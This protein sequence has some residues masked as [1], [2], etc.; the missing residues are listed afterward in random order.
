MVSRR[1]EGLEGQSGG[2]AIVWGPVGPS[3]WVGFKYSPL[4]GRFVV[5]FASKRARI[6]PIA[7]H[8]LEL[9]IDTIVVES[10]GVSITDNRRQ[11][12]NAF[13]RD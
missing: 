10:G 7:V 3:K 5:R 6:V 4:N 13:R 9:S 1:D 11:P 12:E 2:S 8:H